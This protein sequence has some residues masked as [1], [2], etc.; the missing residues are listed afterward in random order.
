MRTSFKLFLTILAI[1]QVMTLT[2]LKE[3]VGDMFNNS[4]TGDLF[5]EA[6]DEHH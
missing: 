5:Q 3:E 1:G 6:I 2:N 4:V